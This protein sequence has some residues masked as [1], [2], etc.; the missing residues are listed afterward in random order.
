MSKGNETN[1][2]KRSKRNRANIREQ[3]R[4]HLKQWYASEMGAVG[5]DAAHVLA[6]ECEEI[7][8]D[9]TIRYWLEPP[10][11]GL[12]YNAVVIEKPLGN[13]AWQISIERELRIIKSFGGM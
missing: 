2:I 13:D 7:L 1:R 12:G 9:G 6:E 11:P 5:E 3:A 10:P 8:L 4:E